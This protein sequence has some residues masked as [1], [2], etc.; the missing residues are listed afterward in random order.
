MRLKGSR[1]RKPE[2]LPA[3][4]DHVFCAI[5]SIGPI[6]GVA[7]FGSGI[8]SLDLARNSKYSISIPQC[9]NVLSIEKN[10]MPYDRVYIAFHKTTSASPF[11]Y[12]K[13]NR[14]RNLS[15]RKKMPFPK[16]SILTKTCSFYTRA[17]ALTFT[18][19]IGFPSFERET[20]FLSVIRWSEDRSVVLCLIIKMRFACEVVCISTL[21]LKSEDGKFSWC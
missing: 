13:K 3:G 18:V 5:E 6:K 7:V 20:S 15:G 21:K 16:K 8:G 4:S 1:P 12:D 14:N 9:I 2:F 17:R 10:P 19:E 11:R